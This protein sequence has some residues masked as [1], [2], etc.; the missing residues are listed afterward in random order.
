M[1]CTTWNACLLHWKIKHGLA[2][3]PARAKAQERA[4]QQ[5]LLA[6]IRQAKTAKKPAC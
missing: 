2:V 1:H 4:A 6:L 3:D 5:G